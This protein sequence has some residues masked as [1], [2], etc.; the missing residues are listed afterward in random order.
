MRIYSSPI[1][2][3]DFAFNSNPLQM[4]INQQ[5]KEEYK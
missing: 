5:H 1:A 3:A 2:S 4:I